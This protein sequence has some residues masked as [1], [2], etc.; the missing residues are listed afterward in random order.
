LPT[1]DLVMEEFFLSL[2]VLSMVFA[3]AS[4]MGFVGFLFY[5]I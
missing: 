2:K 3:G 4:E 5:E 1:A